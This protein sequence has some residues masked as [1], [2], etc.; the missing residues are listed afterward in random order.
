MSSYSEMVSII[1]HINLKKTK[2]KKIKNL[3]LIAAI[4]CLSIGSVYAITTTLNKPTETEQIRIKRQCSR[5]EGTGTVYLKK[6]HAACGGRGCA[7]CNN[8][9]YTETPITCPTCK[10]S[11]EIIVR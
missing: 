10:G 3:L 5:C 8:K 6:T 11:G 7:L 2:M 1:S 9:G 4:A